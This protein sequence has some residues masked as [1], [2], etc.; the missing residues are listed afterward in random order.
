MSEPRRTL[1]Q[2][3]WLAAYQKH[4]NAT[5]ATIDAGYQCKN[6]NVARVIGIENMLKPALIGALVSQRAEISA[7]TGITV[8][9]QQ[10]SLMQDIESAREAKAWGAVMSGHATLLKSIGGMTGDRPHPDAM[11][12]KV[13]DAHKTA[14]LRAIAERYY[15]ERYLAKPAE[16]VTVLDLR[17]LPGPTIDDNTQEAQKNVQ[18]QEQ[19]AGSGATSGPKTQTAAAGYYSQDSQCNTHAC[20]TQCNTLQSTSK[21]GANTAPQ[22]NDGGI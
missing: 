14:D 21:A 3:K 17:P 1:K 12:G 18:G 15:A 16:Q 22:S 11:A 13:L 6:R 4:G 9:K 19:A 10:L 2:E 5:Q 20:N 8:E 7:K